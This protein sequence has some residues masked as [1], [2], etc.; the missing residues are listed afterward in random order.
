MLNNQYTNSP[1]YF[2][3]A[4]YPRFQSNVATDYGPNPFT[5]NISNAAMNNDTFR[6]ALWTGNNLQLTLMSIPAGE[7]IGVEVH[8]DDDQFLHIESGRG[9]V[10]MGKQMDNLNFQQPVFVDSAI[11]VPAGIWHN[12]INT[13]NIPLKLYSI[14]APPHH[15]WGT[16]HQTKAIAEANPNH[17]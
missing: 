2:S 17:Y 4:S 14:Y 5:I 9:V 7:E 11:F 13:G 16:V 6:T 12:I 3:G 10:Q 8:P 1:S 15:P